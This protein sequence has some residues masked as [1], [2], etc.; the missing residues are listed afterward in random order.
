MRSLWHLRRRLAAVATAAV[1]VTACATPSSRTASLVHTEDAE[2]FATLLS[3]GAPSAAMLQAGYLAPGT[4]GI[5]IFT[6]H[7][8]QS[9]DNLAANVAANLARYQHAV[10]VCLPAARVIE[11]RATA[12]L[13]RTATLLGQE[14]NPAS[15]YFLFGANNSGG[16]ADE[17][18]L[19]IGLEVVCDGKSSA[20]DAARV[21][22]EFLAHEV[23]HVYQARARANAGE[24]SFDL[25]Y[26]ALNEGVADFVMEL[27]LDRA[28]DSN[29]ARNAYGLAHER[30]M[31][32]AFLADYRPGEWTQNS[33]FYGPGAEGRPADMG[34]WIGQRIAEAYYEQATDKSQALRDLLELRDPAAILARSGYGAGW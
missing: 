3:D 2:R 33:W 14:G 12:V 7:R 20:E 1:M 9:A 18:G 6:P 25:L 34:Y 23:V 31:W 26:A 16:T 21:F 5:E 32:R 24:I 30:E 15:A 17:R 29:G 28:T 19:A 13:Q 27:S 10:A 11:P 22:E 8:I 4:V